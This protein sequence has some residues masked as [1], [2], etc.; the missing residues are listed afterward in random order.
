MENNQAQAQNS[1]AK[2]MPKLK[3]SE[4]L[5]QGIGSMSVNLIFNVVSTYL[6][7]FYTNVYG[8]K[9][10]DT[11]TMFLLVRII[12]AVA[13]PIYGTWVD[14]RTTKFGKYRGYLLY[15]SL[16]YAI[17]SVLC[18]YSVDTTYVMKLIYA[19]TTYV[20]LSLLNTFLSPL[21]AMP[22]A[23]TRDNDEIA[24]LN[25]YS[26][27]C[28]NVGG[29]CISFGVPF[30]VTGFS[31]AYTG[32]ASQKGWFMTMGIF[33]IVGLVGLLFAFSRI[34]EHYHMTAEATETVS[35]KDI[36]VQM[37]VNK[38]FSIFL[39][40]L[41]L[42]FI[43]MTI[44]NSAGSYY[45]TYNMQRPDLLKYFNLLASIP[46]FILVPLF[47]WFKRRLGR[48]G[49]MLGFSGVLMVGLLILY[50]GNVHNVALVMTGKLLASVGMIVTTGY[51]WA[52]ETE[53]VN[54]GEWKTGKR[55]NAIISS[56]CSFAVALGLALGGVVPGYFLKFIGFDAALKTQ[57]AG[58]LHG[59]LTMQSL[60]PIIFIV[61]SMILF[62]FYSITDSSMDKMS[63]EIDERNAKAAK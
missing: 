13:S 42:A 18:F 24:Q 57:A 45:V 47:P 39:V 44:V 43:F 26:M 61:I 38:P 30:L 53:I 46:S 48:K 14:K 10:A 29:M 50:F 22:A 25:A 11:A 2:V 63:R 5:G 28:S 9:P 31:G 37:K 56:V 1:Q 49:L 33:A 41:I 59:I 60:L 20:G 51:M 15:L 6:L 40:Y 19:Y 16:P 7:F 54:Y 23:M 58:T 35:F 21:G 17:L 32:Q 55:E 27:F 12:D 36:F 3:F 8:L 52:F 4:K 34:H 62:S